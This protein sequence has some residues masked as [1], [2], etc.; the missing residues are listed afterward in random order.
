[1]NAW[2]EWKYMLVVLVS[3]GKNGGKIVFEFYFV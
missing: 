3:R 2:D 1:M